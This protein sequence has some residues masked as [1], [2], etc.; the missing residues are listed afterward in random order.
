MRIAVLGGIVLTLL[1]LLL[2]RL[3]FLQVIGGEQYGGGRGQPPADGRHRRPRGKV[4]DRNGELWWATAPGPT[5]SSTR[6]LTG[7][8]RE[9]V[10][11]RLA[12][13]ST[14][15]PRATSSSASRRGEPPLRVR[16]DRPER[17]P[18]A[19]LLPRP[20]RAAVPGIRLRDS[21]LR[22]YPQGRMAAHVLGGTGR[23]PPRRSTTSAAA[24]EGNETVGKGG[25]SS[26]T[27]ASSAGRRAATRA[28]STRRSGRP[29]ARSCR[30]RVRR[31][32]CDVQLDRRDRP[33]GAEGARRAGLLNG[34]STGA[35]GVALDPDT[36]EVLAL[37]SYG[38]RSLAVRERLPGADRGRHRGPGQGAPQQG[39][40]RQLPGRVDVQGHQRRRRPR[41][42][43][44]HGQRG[45]RVAADRASQDG[46]LE[47]QGGPG[48]GHLPTALEVSSDLLLPAGRRVLP[49]PGSPLQEEARRFG[50]GERTGLDLPARSTA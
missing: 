14:G 33:S 16:R 47:L 40:R 35:A 19:R 1:G 13:S 30:R 7:M 10:L 38:L 6:E 42:R 4:L 5:W 11:N 27:R 39:D 15:S 37:A 2:I 50:L 25:S 12:A 9:Q 44:H 49:G 22:T 21:Y 45:S 8:R 43:L 32:P 20:A 48:Y 28:R 36:G 46:L 34:L 29:A 24:G 3:W 17:A 18:R 26:S 31:S 41:G 23:S